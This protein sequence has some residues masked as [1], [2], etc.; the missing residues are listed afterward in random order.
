[1]EEEARAEAEEVLKQVETAASASLSKTKEMQANVD[2]M[3]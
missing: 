3:M 1:M 2:E